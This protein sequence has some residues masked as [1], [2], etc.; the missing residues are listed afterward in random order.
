MR[1]INCYYFLVFLILFFINI[2]PIQA[3]CEWLYE[4]RD[5]LSYSVLGDGTIELYYC[6]NIMDTIWAPTGYS[7]VFWEYHVNGEE[8]ED[9]DWIGNN[10]L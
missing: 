4:D 9:W 7:D 1:I 5:T 2:L 8:C 3:Q 10:Y 6:E